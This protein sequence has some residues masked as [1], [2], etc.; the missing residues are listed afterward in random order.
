MSDYGR[1]VRF[2]DEVYGAEKP[3]V[4]RSPETGIPALTAA[5]DWLCDGARSVLDF[6]CG[7]GTALCWCALRG[8]ETLTG[9]D[10]SPEAIRQAEARAALMPSGCFD[11]RCGGV[12]A[13]AR[14][15]D[16]AYDGVL[17]MNIL[18][19]LY[20]QD[21]EALLSACSRLLKPGGKALI[22]LNPHLSAE[23][24]DAW[25]IAVLDGNLLD[26]GLLLYNLTDGDW[27]R[28]MGRYLSVQAPEPLNWPGQDQPGR[29]FRARRMG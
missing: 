24:I 27:Q 17:L 21:A 10:L 14:L 23:R 18:D 5:L 9:V 25:G 15:P 1:C 26:D 4:P 29:L 22:T 13:L 16:A 12:E 28:V 19:N 11:C 7:N 8:V 3:A 2:W 6:G 20:P